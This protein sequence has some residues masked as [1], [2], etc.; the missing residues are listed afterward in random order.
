MTERISESVGPVSHPVLQQIREIFLAEE[1]LV[2]TTRFD[3]PISPTELIVEFETG[4]NAAGRFEITWWEQDAYR[5]HYTETDG[6]DFRFDN[7]PKDS[8]PEAH[9]HPPP[10]AGVAEPSILD[11][12]T[13]P[14]IVTRVIHSQWRKAVIEQNDLTSINKK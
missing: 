13:Q 11:G 2:E 12:I 3:T 6:V 4:L 9:F 8:A 14:Q 5:F 10:N 1:P 7:H